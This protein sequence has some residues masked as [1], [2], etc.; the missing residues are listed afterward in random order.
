MIVKNRKKCDLD[1]VA[2]RIIQ[3][4]IADKIAIWIA[5]ILE[6]TSYKILEEDLREL[7]EE[8]GPV[9]D[10]LDDLIDNVMTICEPQVNDIEEIDNVSEATSK[11]TQNS[12]ITYNTGDDTIRIIND[13]VP[14]IEGIELN[15]NDH[16]RG[17]L[18]NIVD[19][20][21][22]EAE[23]GYENKDDLEKTEPNQTDFTS[24]HIDLLPEAPGNAELTSY[25]PV[26]NETDLALEDVIDSDKNSFEDGTDDPKP[27]I[28]NDSEDTSKPVQ[29]DTDVPLEADKP[30]I[31][32]VKTSDVLSDEGSLDD[33]NKKV[34][35]S[36]VQ[37][38]DTRT[39]ESNSTD[40]VF[41]S[42]GHQRERLS[43]HSSI[44]I[45]DIVFAPPNDHLLSD[46]DELWPD[47]ITTP[48]LKPSAS[49]SRSITSLD[50]QHTELEIAT[51]DDRNNS[52]TAEQLEIV[53]NLLVNL[54]D[55]KIEAPIKDE[56]KPDSTHESKPEDITE[57]TTSSITT[58]KTT[59][60]K[61]MADKTVEAVRCV[62]DVTPET[63]RLIIDS[64]TSPIKIAI[65]DDSIKQKQAIGI[66]TDKQLTEKDIK[67]LESDTNV[68]YEAVQQ[69]MRSSYAIAQPKH[70]YK[71]H[72]NTAPSW[73][74]H[75]HGKGEPS[76]DSFLGSKSKDKLKDTEIRNWCK[77][78]DRI[79]VNLEMW[80]DWIDST[81]RNVLHLKQKREMCSCGPNARRKDAR[82][83]ITLKK[84]IDKDAVLWTKLNQK[85]HERLKFY[86]RK[87][88]F[89][90]Q[91]AKCTKQYRST[92]VLN[93]Y[94]N[95]DKETVLKSLQEID[96]LCLWMHRAIVSTEY[97]MLC[98]C[99]NNTKR[100]V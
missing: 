75:D 71:V 79:Y 85:A 4:D 24:E 69:K 29:S 26:Q 62:C 91:P 66:R 42:E 86:K 47:D 11:G 98:D 73:L 37:M 83:W 32:N 97:C 27:V 82:D 54:Q 87:S 40:N 25:K 67:N 81:C 52:Q 39:V 48:V 23:Q 38:D 94:I 78:L 80:N 45:H 99:K 15:I 53:H 7:E 70:D 21:I 58:I 2:N 60:E 88:K 44:D 33:K 100:K 18:Q 77:D 6:D 55:D 72:A 8:E 74:R 16:I 95:E 96:R 20:V 93:T 19:S 50:M 36:E 12:N 35:F 31:E 14:E 64:S 3:A 65:D 59:V 61:T 56:S 41:F 22:P 49:V 51:H 68:I 92:E 63:K 17:E 30:D 89:C 13:V 10:F 1:E 46:A 90:R 84:N 28:D 5:M 76:E 34:K 43:W 9:L 57:E